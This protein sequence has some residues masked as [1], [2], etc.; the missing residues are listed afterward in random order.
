MPTIRFL[1]VQRSIEVPEQ[2]KIL[3][4]ANRMKIGLRF[5][6]ASCRCGTCGITV[7]GT[8]TVSPM[9]TNERELLERMGLNPNQG[10]RLACQTRIISGEI[11][12]DLDFQNTYSPD[13]LVGSE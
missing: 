7:A 9:Q 3:V 2:T 1:P 6:C 11:D 13:D 10:V 4:A 12:V 5:G 8:G